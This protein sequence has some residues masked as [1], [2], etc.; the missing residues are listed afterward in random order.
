MKHLALLCCLIFPALL[1]AQACDYE[2][3]FREGKTFARQRQYKK[4]LYKFNSARRCDPGKGE[5][6]DAAIEA[7]L[8]QVEGE[9]KA[10]DKALEE[11]NKQQERNERIINLFYFYD[12]RIALASKN[13]MYG[14][15][16]KEGNTLIDFKYS[17]AIPFDETGY[18]HV[19]RYDNSYLIDTTG[20]EYLLANKIS[21][22]DSNTT[23]LDLSGQNL[24]TIPEEVFMS[25]QL[26]I[27][28]LNNNNLGFLP[29]NIG[30]LSRLKVLDLSN[31][32]LFDLPESI[33][34]LENLETFNLGDNSF[35]VFPY[36]VNKLRNL[37]NLSFSNNKLNEWPDFE[38]LEKLHNLDLSYNNLE[39]LPKTIGSL[40]ELKYLNISYNKL[41]EIP[42]EIG[43]LKKL[44]TL[45]LSEDSLH[46]LPPAIGN[47][48][49]LHSLDISENSFF[50]IPPE[51][52]KLQKLKSLNVM[53]NEEYLYQGEDGVFLPYGYG[54]EVYLE[55]FPEEICLLKSLKYLNLSGNIIEHLPKK[56]VNL[57]NLR[58]LDTRNTFI[59]NDERYQLRTLMPW[60][61]III[62]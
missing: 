19:F 36:V 14:F 58:T 60:C 5:T 29:S 23:A 26:K 33:I 2:R 31:N 52:G 17:E 44:K 10:A 24:D 30:Q 40:T 20:Y 61:E 55:Q 3:L 16:D 39:F 57:K 45:V 43:N 56:T 50:S 28:F 37:K 9:K 32:Q 27:L 4:A 38:R 48:I 11:L 21:Q 47:L 49:E 53:I 51:I 13:G 15:I 54:K 18:A 25:E 41:Y 59:S 12:D 7:L 35:K 46:A 1:A 22:L 8:D 62:D 34:E 6:V 42:A